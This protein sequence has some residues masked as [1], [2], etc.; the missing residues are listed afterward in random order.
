LLALA[1]FISSG[2][3]VPRF[4]QQQRLTVSDGFLIAAVINAIGLF[5]TD[6]LTYKW[7]GMAD[8]SADGAEPSLDQVIALK[9]V[10]QHPF[11]TLSEKELKIKILGPI[12]W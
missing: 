2:R 7:G 6:T 1:I 4:L 9:K 11:G 10:R 5:I 12:R 3:L 8:E